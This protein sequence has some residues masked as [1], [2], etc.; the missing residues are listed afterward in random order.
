MLAQAVEGLL[1]GLDRNLQ[2]TP[3]DTPYL[4]AGLRFGGTQLAYALPLRQHAGTPHANGE[5]A[6]GYGSQAYRADNA[7]A[8]LEDQ[9]AERF[10]GAHGRSPRWR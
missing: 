10:K 3:L 5:Q 8:L 4:F 2:L 1:L 6:Y 9:A 7:Q